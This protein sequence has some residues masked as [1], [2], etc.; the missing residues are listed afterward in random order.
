MCASTSIVALLIPASSPSVQSS[1]R[2]E[3]PLRS[4]HRWYIL[5]IIAAQSMASTPPAPDT[6]LTTHPMLSYVPESILPSSH[7]PSSLSISR[8]IAEASRSS[9]SSSSPSSTMAI[10][11]WTS[12]HKPLSLS[13]CSSPA[14][15]LSS[16][17]I[18][19]CAASALSQKP[20][21]VVWASLSLTTSFKLFSST[22]SLKAPYL[23]LT[24]VRVLRISSLISPVSS[25][26]FELIITPPPSPKPPTA[27]RAIPTRPLALMLLAA[28]RGGMAGKRGWRP[29]LRNSG[30]GVWKQRAAVEGWMRAWD[31]GALWAAAQ[32]WTRRGNVGGKDR[33]PS[34]LLPTIPAPP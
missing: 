28:S 6:M 8:I 16:S 17:C 14:F 25:I 27:M 31:G 12:S 22:A 21:S 29:P 24:S 3:Y 33:T 1:S 20:S 2:C 34:P 4:A 10:T 23:S 26:D 13:A 11:V 5:S 15:A 9:S 30:T 7:S 32:R 18:T 19:F